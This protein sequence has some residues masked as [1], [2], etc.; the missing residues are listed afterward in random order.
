[1]I[2]RCVGSKLH[3]SRRGFECYSMPT[4]S[5]TPSSTR[6]LSA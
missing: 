6:W 3:Q 4:R 1:L 5:S 2:P